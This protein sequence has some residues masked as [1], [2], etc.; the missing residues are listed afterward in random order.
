MDTLPSELN[1][2]IIVHLTQD[3]FLHCITVCKSWYSIFIPLLY[4]D[5][6]LG[7]SHY[8][9]DEFYKSM[10]TYPRCRE[11]GIYVRRLNLYNYGCISW[12]EFKELIGHLPSIEELFLPDIR[13]WINCFISTNEPE[14]KSLKKID[15]NQSFHFYGSK[16]LHCYYQH[17]DTLTHINIFGDI[18]PQEYASTFPFYLPSFTQLTHLEL[19]VTSVPHL[20]SDLFNEILHQVPHITTL[21]YTALIREKCFLDTYPQSEHHSLTHMELKMDVMDTR[22][23]DYIKSKFPYLKCLK[24]T[25]T[26]Q[27][28]DACQ[29][30][31]AVTSI[32]SLTDLELNFRTKR[33]DEYTELFDAWKRC[34]PPSPLIQHAHESIAQ[35]GPQLFASPISLS[36]S[37]SPTT[38]I[39]RMFSRAVPRKYRIQVREAYLKSHGSYLTD[40]SLGNRL[41]LMDI[42]LPE[43]NALC[44]SLTYLTLTY[45]TLRSASTVLANCNLRYL[46][47]TRCLVNQC[48]LNAIEQHYPCLK[49]ISLKGC[50]LEFSG[51]RHP[52]HLRLPET[53]LEVLTIRL[54][55][56]DLEK[57]WA[58]V[59]ENGEG[60]VRW[61]RKANSDRITIN[62]DTEF[63]LESVQYVMHSSTLKVFSLE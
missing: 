62:R 46:T 49:S 31:E 61:Y 15:F 35:K 43:L 8:D 42:S 16:I 32:T 57:T 53:G 25:I 40:L 34:Y 45:S 54:D 24:M 20:G 17:R 39:R 58:V 41:N 36:F 5:I 3:D 21:T 7:T 51:L 29:S 23:I 55:M 63:S 13:Y 30:I 1:A 22:D 19:N 4:Q 56:K 28:Q 47:L 9:I 48:V 6:K 14:L 11:A 59:K 52:Y 10:T 2:L 27:L 12:T 18:K 26:K 38:G 44:P 37:I 60:A 50:K 33:S